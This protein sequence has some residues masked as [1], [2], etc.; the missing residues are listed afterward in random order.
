MNAMSDNPAGQWLT[1]SLGD[2]TDAKDRLSAAFRGTTTGPRVTFVSLDLLWRILT[3]TR[4][5]LLQ[6]MAGKGPLSVDDLAG[7]LRRDLKS[8]DDDARAL[9]QAG[10]LRVHRPDRLVFPYDGFRV[11][12][13]LP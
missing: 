7:L 8:V 2:L 5:V 11:D 10:L 9:F 3:P 12:Y 1:V 4:Q 13:T 6:T